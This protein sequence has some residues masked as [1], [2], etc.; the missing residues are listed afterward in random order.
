MPSLGYAETV[1][2]TSTDVARTSIDFYAE[3]R[4]QL[5]PRP[6]VRLRNDL[7]MMT[8]PYQPPTAGIHSMICSQRSLAR[9]ARIG[10]LV[11]ILP[12]CLFMGQLSRAK[13]RSRGIDVTHGQ[14]QVIQLFSLLV[15][16]CRADVGVGWLAYRNT[17]HVYNMGTG[18]TVTHGTRILHPD[19]PGVA[20]LKRGKKEGEKRVY[21]RTI[22]NK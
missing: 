21:V 20:L 19:G 3:P 18:G 4:G 7:R 5:Q 14:V 1:C 10:G 17:T 11:V 22:G 6:A 13:G 15:S 16:C 9:Q 12:A 2:I 8:Q